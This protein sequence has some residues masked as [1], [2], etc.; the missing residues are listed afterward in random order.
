[1]VLRRPISW[2]G[3]PGEPLVREIHIRRCFQAHLPLVQWLVKKLSQVVSCQ[4]PKAAIRT[5]NPYPLD[6]GNR[7]QG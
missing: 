7:F 3:G 2:A 6:H 1:M 5:P 4:L